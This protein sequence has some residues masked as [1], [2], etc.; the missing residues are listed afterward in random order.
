MKKIIATISFVLIFIGSVLSQDDTKSFILSLKFAPSIDFMQPNTKDYKS[1][2]VL[3]K[4]T[5]GL[6]GDIAIGGSGHYFLDLGIQFK[7]TGGKLRYDDRVEITAGVPEFAGVQR[8]YNINYVS[9]PV[10]F[11]LKTAQFGRLTYFGLFG[12]DNSIRVK[13]YADDTYDRLAPNTD[14]EI[15]KIDIKEDVSLFKESII[16]GAG[17]EYTISGNTK[18]Y[19]GIVF[20]NGFTDV[21]KGSNGKFTDTKENALNKSIELM[22]GISF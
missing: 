20:Y 2:G 11:K 19:A 16:I 15:N 14:I 7:N 3:L 10:A 5:Y 1:D 21:L 18:A 17:T 6:I 9:L 12:I 22:I 8:K 13:A 4:Y